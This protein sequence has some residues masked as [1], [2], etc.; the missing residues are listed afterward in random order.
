MIIGIGTDLPDIKRIEKLLERFGERFIV[1]CFSKKERA[2]AKQSSTQKG[3]SATFAKRFAAKEACAKALGMGFADGVR[4]NDISII[5]D[6][7][8]RPFLKLENG[9]LK[10]LKAITP[11]GKTA[12]LHLSLSDEHPY[13]QAFVVIEAV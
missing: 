8:G 4:M 13:A 3:Q 9:A 1:R 12:H 11:Q 6:E 5:T 7:N 2:K 10:R